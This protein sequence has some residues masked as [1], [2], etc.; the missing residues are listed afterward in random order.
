M[1]ASRDGRD[2]LL[3]PPP[4]KGS[5]P[6][7][8]SARP[9][10]HAAR[11][12]GRSVGGGRSG[13]GDVAGGGALASLLE[14]KGPLSH[15]FFTSGQLMIEEYCAITPRRCALSSPATTARGSLSPS[16]ANLVEIAWTLVGQAAHGPRDRHLIEIVARG[17]GDMIA[18]L[19]WR[20]G[21]PCS[22]PARPSSARPIR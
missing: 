13:G 8:T 10:E 12:R 20:S 1:S 19:A 18:Q 5:A 2:G 22:W 15:A 21:R 4:H 14:S 6:V 16:V 9:A 11:P 17:D 7:A 3:P